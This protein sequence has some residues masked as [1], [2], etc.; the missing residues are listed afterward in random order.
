M[1]FDPDCVYQDC[2]EWIIIMKLIGHTNENRSN[3]LNKKCAKF[4]AKAIQTIAIVNA[5]QLNKS[6]HGL[7]YNGLIYEVGKETCDPNYKMDFLSIEKVYA[8][9]AIYFFNTFQPCYFNRRRAWIPLKNGKLIGWHETTGKQHF[10]GY[11]L[12]GVAVFTNHWNE[13]G[14][15]LSL[16]E[17][18]DI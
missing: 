16:E 8:K 11:W 12:N 15:S 3:V 9:N 18:V 2:H 10:L 1:N 13:K 17:D 14:K 6:V 4:R 7:Y 5:A